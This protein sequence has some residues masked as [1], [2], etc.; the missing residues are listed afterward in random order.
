M[1]GQPWWSLSGGACGPLEPAREA[2]AGQRSTGCSDA[3]PAVREG[4]LAQ[5]G[6]L[7]EKGVLMAAG[8]AQEGVMQNQ[9]SNPPRRWAWSWG[10]SSWG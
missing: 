7:S 8:C 10:R 6:A 2:A 1:Q 9:R 5:A 4:S 3:G